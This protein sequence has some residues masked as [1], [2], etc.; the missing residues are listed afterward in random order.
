VISN[1]LENL[2]NLWIQDL[3]LGKDNILRCCG[4]DANIGVM[5]AT[6]DTIENATKSLYNEI[7]KLQIAADYQYRVDLLESHTRRIN[8]LT[9]MGINVS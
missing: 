2:N 7:D 6:G 4:V 3:F 5:V 1:K 9:K 8:K